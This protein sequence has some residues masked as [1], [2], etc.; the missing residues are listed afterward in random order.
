MGN[1]PAQADPL[2]VLALLLA[3]MVGCCVVCP[4]AANGLHTFRLY[5]K[6]NQHAAEMSTGMSTQASRILRACVT[7]GASAF[8]E[9]ILI[10][11]H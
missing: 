6:D 4:A 9:M 11:T 7:I 1:G 10:D 5:F 3:G 2:G 8:G